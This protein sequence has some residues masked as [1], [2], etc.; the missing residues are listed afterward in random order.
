MARTHFLQADL[1]W[2]KVG[3][4]QTKIRIWSEAEVLARKI[5]TDCISQ[6]TSEA[7][8][9]KTLAGE[10]S[11]LETDG[12][13]LEFENIPDGWREENNKSLDGSLV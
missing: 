9:E 1:T 3:V 8:K 11:W 5:I 4:K 13:N 6:A 7:E 12:A 2:A 10:V